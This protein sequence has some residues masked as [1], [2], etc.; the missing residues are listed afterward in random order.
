MLAAFPPMY[1]CICLCTRAA[2]SFVYLLNLAG[3][4]EEW[5]VVRIKVLGTGFGERVQ[6]EP[7][8]VE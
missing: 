2:A 7:N 6:L 8:V 3:H 5:T 4:S 1:I